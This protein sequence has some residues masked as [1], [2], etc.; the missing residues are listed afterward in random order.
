MKG[1]VYS[2]ISYLPDHPDADLHGLVRVVVREMNRMRVVQRLEDAGVRTLGIWTTSTWA[3]SKSH[4]EHQAAVEF[5]V[6]FACPLAKQYLTIEHYR[7]ISKG[8]LAKNRAGQTHEEARPRT[9]MVPKE[10]AR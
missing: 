7:P 10:S 6:L 1:T 5:G 9:G 3:A 8:V 4:V 2:G